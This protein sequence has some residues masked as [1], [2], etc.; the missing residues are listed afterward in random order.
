MKTT[1]DYFTIT[2]KGEDGAIKKKK[3]GKKRRGLSWR[4]F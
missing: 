1:T 2:K 3:D 4:V